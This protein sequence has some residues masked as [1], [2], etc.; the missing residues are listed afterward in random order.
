MQNLSDGNKP[1][2]KKENKIRLFRVSVPLPVFLLVISVPSHISI[3]FRA[4]F[5]PQVT[6]S[7]YSSGKAQHLI[8]HF[9]DLQKPIK[10]PLF[11]FCKL[12]MQNEIVSVYFQQPSTIQTSMC[13]VSGL[14]F[15]RKS[16]R[17]NKVPLEQAVDEISEG[18][19]MP[20]HR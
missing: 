4:T 20:S 19:H 6:S 18:V 16:E 11:Q 3:S 1:K 12:R 8:W 7:A 17:L 5:P 10:S 9:S 15:F 14:T 2:G 13:E